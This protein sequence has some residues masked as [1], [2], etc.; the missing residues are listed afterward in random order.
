MKLGAE[1]HPPHPQGATDQSK[2]MSGRT[3][4]GQTGV[5]ADGPPVG[6]PH[7]IND[8]IEAM[9][10][11]HGRRV[12]NEGRPHLATVGLVGHAVLALLE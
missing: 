10:I 4:S 3:G 6:T 5:V 11:R 9:K 8:G 1:D 12:N 7:R 2:A